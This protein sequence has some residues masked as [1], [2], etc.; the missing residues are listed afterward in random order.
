MGA[1]LVSFR[2]TDIVLPLRSLSSAP[3][4]W[5]ASWVGC[6][7]AIAQACC[8]T[9]GVTYLVVAL[10]MSLSVAGLV[11]A[12]M[13]ATSVIGRMSLGWLAD[14]AVSSTTTLAIAAVGSAA[15]TI[16]FGFAAPDW[17]VWAFV[18]LAAVAGFSV[19]GWNGV[20]IAEVARR[21][22]PELIPECAAGSVILVFMSNMLA[23]IA[24]AACVA[25]TNRYDYAFIAAGAFSLICLPL[26]YGIDRAREESGPKPGPKP[27]M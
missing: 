12:V 15:S 9:F 3:T 8:V 26:L 2:L 10:G 21:S 19:S 23:P 1:R 5:R 17:P 22:P 11:F 20:Q 25:L 7:L 18:L 24:F 13:Q 16:A 6:L 27:E 4:L 14:H